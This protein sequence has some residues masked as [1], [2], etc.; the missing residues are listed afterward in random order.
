VIKDFLM[1]WHFAENSY[2]K[3]QMEECVD[4]KAAKE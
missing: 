4:S 2:S 1:M 3:D